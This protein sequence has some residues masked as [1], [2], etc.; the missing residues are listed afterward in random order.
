MRSEQEI[1]DQLTLAK[2]I[3]VSDGTIQPYPHANVV[4]AT[5][6]WALGYTA[7]PPDKQPWRGR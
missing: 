7:T 1:V 2:R 5:L 4:E 6:L 3:H